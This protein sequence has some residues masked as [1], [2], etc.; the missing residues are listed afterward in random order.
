MNN[1]F[2][3]K[4]THKKKLK[5]YQK[6]SQLEHILDLPDTYIGSIELTKERRYV[7]DDEGNMIEKDVEYVPGFYKI[8]DEI[9]VNARDHKVRDPALKNIKFK[10]DADFFQNPDWV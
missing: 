9:I 2:I 4:K 7:L 8:V 10:V 1:I 5:K 6:K 3:W